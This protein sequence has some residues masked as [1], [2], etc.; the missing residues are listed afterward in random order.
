[1]DTIS[2]F[3]VVFDDRSRLFLNKRMETQQSEWLYFLTKNSRKL[4]SM[5]FIHPLYD[6]NM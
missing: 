6:Y 2:V 5:V 1:M 4:R 3:V